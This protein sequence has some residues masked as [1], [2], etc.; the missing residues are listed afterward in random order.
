MEVAGLLELDVLAGFTTGG[1]EV[2]GDGDGLLA[3]LVVGVDSTGAGELVVCKHCEY[4][5]F[6]S[7]QAQPDTQV[8]PPFQLIPPPEK[9]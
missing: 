2:D 8:V 7:T 4:H 3:G 9:G 6:C 5:G 1:A